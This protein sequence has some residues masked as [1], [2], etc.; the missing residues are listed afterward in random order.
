M[1]HLMM[2]F[3][4]TSLLLLTFFVSRAQ[5]SGT[6]SV[7]SISANS[8]TI[9][10]AGLTLDGTGD[11]TDMTIQ[12]TGGYITG[13]SGDILSYTGSL[14][15]GITS[16]FDNVHGI[17]RFFGT[18]SKSNWQALLR[19][20]TL[21][22]TNATCY[23]QKRNV[24]FVIGNKL[25]NPTNGH[26][27]ALS[28]TYTDWATTR[29]NA[30]ETSYYGRKGYLATLTSQDENN[31]VW[32]MSAY[33]FTW[34][35]ASDNY[36]EINNLTGVTTY[37]NQNLSE[38]NFYWLTGPESGTPFSS[39]NS[40]N[41]GPNSIS[42]RWINW[43]GSQPDDYPTTNSSVNG[44]Q[45]FV[46]M[47][48]F[49]GE[50]DDEKGTN[51]AEGIYEYGDMPLDAITNNVA[52][53]TRNISISSGVSSGTIT[54][55]DVN[56]CPGTNSTTLTLT[57]LTG[58]VVRWESSQYQN[59]SS[60]TSISNTTTSLTVTNLNQTTYYRAI[61]NS[62]SPASCSNLP[63]SS[64]YINV[65]ATITGNILAE[66]NTICAGG[67][68]KLTLYGN[69][70][71]ILK[72]QRDVN[73]NFSTATDIAN[74]TNTYNQVLSTS[75]ATYYYRAQVQNSGCGS[76]A[77]TPGITITV[78]TGTPSVGGL[79]DSKTFCGGSNSGTLTLTGK[80]GSVTK[81]QQSTDNGLVWTNISNTGT[82][83]NFS[84][85]TATTLYRAVVQ[86]GTCP[87]DNSLPGMA[88]VTNTNGYWIG[89]T[90]TNWQ[91]TANWCGSVPTLTT[92]VVV[93]SGVANLPSLSSGIGYC[94][95]LTVRNGATL[96]N[97]AVLKIAGNIASTGLINTS[98]GSVHF[99]GSSAQSIPAS[100]FSSG[101]IDTLTI[102]NTAGLTI[103]APLKV[104]KGLYLTNGVIKSTTSNLLTLE[105][106]IIVVGGSNSSYIDG[107]VRKTLFKIGSTTENTFTFPVG[108]N[109][110]FAPAK[111]L[112]NSGNNGAYVSNFTIEYFNTPYSDLSVASGLTRVSSKEYWN[113]DRTGD[114]TAMDVTLFFY[115]KVFS[116]VINTASS[117]LIVAHYNGS[118][119]EDISTLTNTTTSTSAT[120]EAVNTFSPFTFGSLGGLN[121][122]PVSLINFTAIPNQ[123][124]KT[125]DLNWQTASEENNKYFEV[126]YSTDLVNW[127]TI[128][129]LNSKGSSDQLNSYFM[130][131]NKTNA[132]NYYKLKQV[133]NDGKYA[134]SDIKV[135]KFNEGNNNV[136]VYPNPSAGIVTIQNA[137]D[138]NYQVID[139]TGKVIMN[140]TFNNSIQL[141]NLPK[142]LFVIRVE[143]E[144]GVHTEKIIV[145]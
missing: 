14:P 71:T 50:W 11:L 88:E 55:G 39:G 87:S 41:S 60:T 99:V 32:Q 118:D 128:G 117:D 28:G 47:Y 6:G 76:P 108:K 1:K 125:V 85:V 42:S 97:T 10:D 23:S 69:Q 58:T 62:T 12:I 100:V 16:S 53:S 111:L 45:D 5:I 26:F 92:D 127:K 82:T 73:S 120:L 77:F 113:I 114:Q 112:R 105:N 122:L 84:S 119:W 139:I 141:S 21:K 106:F 126:M 130:I 121:P 57:G 27:Y 94:K 17:L 48:S 132:I 89:G 144:E 31:F 93:P 25:Y 61:V 101:T 123:S 83:N 80:T 29:T 115:D 86:N 65:T 4:V 37:A 102:N 91:T 78:V 66:S 143:S 22:T 129:V 138:A 136:V 30:S 74:T 72:W 15:S 44:E 134:F 70:V 54:G 9:V 36:T 49:S 52:H 35:G 13:A 56:V 34:L 3:S 103:L 43:S 96:T 8:A 135:V 95:N 75:G 24:T 51:A 46:L 64:T 145:E 90:S 67:T 131:H 79:V 40:W 98:G 19:T 68:V 20:V 107:P 33:L 109:G 81:W 142:G 59:F 116:G 38:G 7:L 63:T 2:R 104:F 124:T 137:T 110:K 140:G 133:D 18:T